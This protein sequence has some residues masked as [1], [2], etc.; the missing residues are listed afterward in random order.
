MA[1]VDGLIDVESADVTVNSSF[2]LNFDWGTI[3][4]IVGACVAVLI[5]IFHSDLH[6]CCTEQTSNAVV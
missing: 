2:N 6:S 4:I 1:N 5:V 3:G